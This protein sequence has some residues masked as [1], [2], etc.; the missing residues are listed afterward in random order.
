VEAVSSKDHFCGSVSRRLQGHTPQPR[1]E[2]LHQQ[3]KPEMD[4]SM[5]SSHRQ[6]RPPIGNHHRHHQKREIGITYEHEK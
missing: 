2:V 5:V 3:P 1:D 4:P 6:S